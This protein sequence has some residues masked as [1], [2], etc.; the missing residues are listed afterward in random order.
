MAIFRPNPS[1]IFFLDL[2]PKSPIHIGW[3]YVK[4]SAHDLVMLGPL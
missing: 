3:I 2:V 4:K 1:Q